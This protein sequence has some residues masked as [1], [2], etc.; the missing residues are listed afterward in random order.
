MR[1]AGLRN[2]RAVAEGAA[3][4]RTQAADH[5]EIAIALP[6]ALPVE[7]FSKKGQILAL[8]R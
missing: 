7:T 5:R 8:T 3:F 1:R 2:E 4:E 6:I